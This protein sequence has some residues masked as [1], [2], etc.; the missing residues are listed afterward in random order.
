[1]GSENLSGVIKQVYRHILP[2]N[3]LRIKTYTQEGEQLSF[4]AVQNAEILITEPEK[5]DQLSSEVIQA[6]GGEI[7]SGNEVE[8]NVSVDTIATRED[9][10]VSSETQFDITKDSADLSFD[11]KSRANLTFYTKLL[12]TFNKA[13]KDYQQKRSEGRKAL[14]EYLPS[15]VYEGR[16]LDYYE[17]GRNIRNLEALEEIYFA[18]KARGISVSEVDERWGSEGRIYLDIVRELM[19]SIEESKENI[20]QEVQKWSPR[21]TFKIALDAGSLFPSLSEEQRVRMLALAGYFP[22]EI[23]KLAVRIGMST[24]LSISLGQAYEYVG[25]GSAALGGALR[26]NSS[27]SIVAAS[28]A[29]Y[30]GAM[31]ANAEINLRLLKN[32]DIATSP[33]ITATVAYYLLD[34]LLPHEA[35]LNNRNTIRDWTTRAA[36]LL[37]EPVKEL[38]WAGTVF[39]PEIGM[40]MITAANFAGFGLNTLQAIYA[41]DIVKP[42]NQKRLLNVIGRVG[43]TIRHPVNNIKQFFDRSQRPSTI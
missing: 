2:L 18:E 36:S 5:G 3:N 35:Q 42:E 24:A 9:V 37:M 17:D 8:H 27:L 10:G 26:F 43:Q 22:E 6:T 40:S 28:Y 21:K 39:I 12:S 14:L 41:K 15:G 34:R 23:S 13:C 19:P 29:M 20:L 7:V 38:G 31:L 30:Y 16:V 11:Q 32:K 25:M 33:N 4:M 1:M